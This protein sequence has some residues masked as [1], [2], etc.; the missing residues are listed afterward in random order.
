M[1]DGSSTNIEN[2]I[3]GARQTTRSKFLPLLFAKLELM[4][5]FIFG[6]VD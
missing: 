2:T 3:A 6:R 4:L 1:A 5:A